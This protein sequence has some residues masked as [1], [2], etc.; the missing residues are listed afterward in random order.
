MD[1]AMTH[2]FEKCVILMGKCVIVSS[3][4]VTLSAIRDA[5]LTLFLEMCHRKF[6]NDSNGLAELVTQ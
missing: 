5:S 4:R 2:Y 6:S 3:L 1:D